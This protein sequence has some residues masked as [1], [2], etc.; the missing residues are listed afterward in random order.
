[1]ERFCG[2]LRG[3]AKSKASRLGSAKSG[4]AARINGWN[5]GIRVELFDNDGRDTVAVYA[6]AGRNGGKPDVLV[7]FDREGGNNG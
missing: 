2:E 4:L 6:T 7:Y 1:M 3:K 5:I